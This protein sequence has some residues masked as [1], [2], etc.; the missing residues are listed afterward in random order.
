M[1]CRM[2]T[3]DRRRPS[4]RRGGDPRSGRRPKFFPLFSLPTGGVPACHATSR[5]PCPPTRGCSATGPTSKYGQRLALPCHSTGRQPTDRVTTSEPRIARTLTPQHTVQS[6]V[7][8][9]A[10]SLPTDSEVPCSGSGHYRLGSHPFR[11]RGRGGVPDK[12]RREMEGV[13]SPPCRRGGVPCHLRPG[14]AWQSS[15]PLTRG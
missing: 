1:T 9:V 11:R 8:Q 14:E 10:A 15:S 7:D 2:R 4:R 12:R 3:P 5:Q 13:L 6:T